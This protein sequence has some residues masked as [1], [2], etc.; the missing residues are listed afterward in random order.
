M[1]PSPDPDTGYEEQCWDQDLRDPIGIYG[2]AYKKRSLQKTV[3]K[4]PKQ[5]IQQHQVRNAENITSGFRRKK[6]CPDRLA[7]E[8]QKSDKDDI[9]DTAHQG[10]KQRIPGSAQEIGNPGQHKETDEQPYISILSGD[11]HN[12][13]SF[14]IPQKL[15][16]AMLIIRIIRFFGKV[17]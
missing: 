11:V 7:P 16:T 6:S 8:Q 5:Q 17:K 3:F 14:L 1:F 15:K 9:V 4:D 12:L 10:I 2:I 13:A